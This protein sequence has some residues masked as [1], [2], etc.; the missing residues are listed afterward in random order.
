MCLTQEAEIAQ[1][2]DSSLSVWWGQ[3][4]CSRALEGGILGRPRDLVRDWKEER[5][6]SFIRA[7]CLV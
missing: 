6:E 7:V 2:E 4:G 3:A 5:E 1:T